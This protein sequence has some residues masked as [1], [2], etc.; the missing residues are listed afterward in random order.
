ML[1]LEELR[2]NSLKKKKLKRDFGNREMYRI[3]ID[4]SG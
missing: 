2:G 1:S 4:D 3:E